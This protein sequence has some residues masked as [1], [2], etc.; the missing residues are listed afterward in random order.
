MEMMTMAQTMDRQ[1]ADEMR[2][3]LAEQNDEAVSHRYGESSLN[4]EEF[5]TAQAELQRRR[6]SE[7]NR[8][9]E[10]M[11]EEEQEQPLME[12]QDI[13]DAQDEQLRQSQQQEEA[14]A[15]EEAQRDR[16]STRL[17][18]SHVSIS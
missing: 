8:G 6:A 10:A 5:R 1:K 17:N 9:L 3:L 16:K 2:R 11:N 15:Q 4:S 18:S 7:R 13:Q 14:A 12:V